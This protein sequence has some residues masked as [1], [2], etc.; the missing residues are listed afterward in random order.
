MRDENGRWKPGFT[1][2]A[3][4]KNFLPPDIKKVKRLTGKYVKLI[5]SKLCEMTP[6]ELEAYIQSGT[7]KNIEVMFAS[8]LMNAIQRGDYNRAEFLMRRSI[9]N[10][11]EEKHV[12]VEPVVYKTS[13]EPDGTMIQNVI[14]S[15]VEGE[16]IIDLD[17]F[18]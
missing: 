3:E 13:I 7:A 10:V 18:K 1:G 15:E 5:I 12:M 14:K 6:A 4:R 8:I 11:V 17:D 16:D 9:G 2:H